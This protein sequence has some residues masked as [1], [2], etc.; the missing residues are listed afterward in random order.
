MGDNKSDGPTN[1][2]KDEEQNKLLTEND[3]KA[4]EIISSH[5]GK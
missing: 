3:L 4:I 2:F 5:T 1:G